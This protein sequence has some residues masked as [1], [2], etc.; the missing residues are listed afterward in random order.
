MSTQLDRVGS[1]AVFVDLEINKYTGRETVDRASIQFWNLTHDLIQNVGLSLVV[2]TESD[3]WEHVGLTVQR[4][5]DEGYT[6]EEPEVSVY[7]THSTS[8]V[9]DYFDAIGQHL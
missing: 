5:I 2:R 9:V 7:R 1:I 8:L 6:I 4:L 3:L